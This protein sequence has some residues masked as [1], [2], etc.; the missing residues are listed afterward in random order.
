[1]KILAI[2]TSTRFLCLGAW[3]DGKVYEYN[4]EVA[5]LLSDLLEPTVKRVLAALAWRIEDI[6]YFVCGLGPG[7]FTGLRVGVAFMKGLGWSLKKPIVGVPTLDTLAKGASLSDAYIMPV[8][9]AKR[10]LIYC[11]LY[12]S[13]NNNLKK[14]L[15][16]ML[17]DEDSLVTKAKADTVFLGDAI[18]LYKDR[19]MARAKGARLMDKDWWYPK[20]HNMIELALGKIKNNKKTDA[21]DIEPIYLY[22]KECQIRVK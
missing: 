5:T 11:S 12:K 7:S 19:I 1:M 9:D 3:E 14:I 8:I 15:P 13:K 16:Y 10:N 22:P 6:D 4:L 17:L 20:A 21:F 18:G 2:D